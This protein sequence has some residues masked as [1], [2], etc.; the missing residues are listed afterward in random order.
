MTT[1]YFLATTALDSHWDTNKQIIFLG[2]WCIRY[3]ELE[4]YRTLSYQVLPDQWQDKSDRINAQ[5]YIEETYQLF[6]IELSKKLNQIHQVEHGIRFWEILIGPWLRVY[7]TVLYDRF[8]SLE[9]VQ[10]FFPDI[11]T[12]GVSLEGKEPPLD[13]GDFVK[14]L[15]S[16]ELNLEIYTRLF[17]YLN[18]AFTVKK[19]PRKQISNPVSTKNMKDKVR[20]WCNRIFSVLGN[21]K[22]I[23]IADSGISLATL[24]K[25][26]VISR[27]HVVPVTEFPSIQFS[28]NPSLRAQLGMINIGRSNMERCASKLIQYYFP[29]AYL[30]GFSALFTWAA[31]FKMQ[32]KAIFSAMGWHYNERLKYLA[33]YQHSFK[34]TL[35]CGHQHGGDYGL[36][37]Y[38]IAELHERRIVDQFYTWGWSQQDT[39]NVQ[40]IPLSG[41]KLKPKRTHTAKTSGTGILYGCANQYRYV[42]RF[43]FSASKQLE[44][45]AMQREFVENLS[46]DY[47]E[48]LIVRLYP[49]DWGWDRKERWQ[50]IHAGL[51]FQDSS[52]P[53][54]KALSA[55]KIYIADHI[56]TTFAEAFA[57]NKP[58]ILF[59]DEE[60]WEVRDEA[61]PFF[62]LLKNAGIY[63]NNAKEAAQQLNH[64]YENIEDWWF[65]EKTQ[66]AIQTFTQQFCRPPS[67]SLKEWRQM[68]RLLN[69]HCKREF[70]TVVK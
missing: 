60:M 16:D 64:I 19:L 41:L 36:L 23:L 32:P 24:A 17:E 68:F 12:M 5:L 56:S 69:T 34:N 47:I 35:L 1:N 48:D 15:A 52:V 54:P 42:R 20:S 49:Q 29:K 39:H 58:T 28:A 53:F 30:E 44:Y 33:A 66:Q 46:P 11:L 14:S 70:S 10:A 26:F 40:C 67:K 3:C 4:K 59:C 37:S 50:A 63:F 8:S 45:Y 31:E 27:G 65:A 21:K 57:A 61:K 55:C 62:V 38:H 25:F 43:N 18:I 2:P 51:K 13:N 7:L 22:G 6:L 9:K